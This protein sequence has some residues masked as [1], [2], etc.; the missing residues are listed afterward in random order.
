MR[1][2]SYESPLIEPA[3]SLRTFCGLLTICLIEGSCLHRHLWQ[4]RTVN[5]VT[6]CLDHHPGVGMTS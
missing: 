2:K 6:V 5:H 4:A 1:L 3:R